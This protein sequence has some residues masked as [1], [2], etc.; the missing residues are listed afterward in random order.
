MQLLSRALPKHLKFQLPHPL[1]DSGEIQLKDFRI[2][3]VLTKEASEE[4]GMD[5]LIFEGMDI[6]LVFK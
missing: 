6:P 4:T 5:F 1:E 3:N 2:Y